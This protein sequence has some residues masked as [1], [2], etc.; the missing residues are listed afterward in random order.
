[1][2]IERL[3]ILMVGCAGGWF[4]HVGY[5]ARERRRR[6]RVVIDYSNVPYLSPGNYSSTGVMS[7]VIIQRAKD[8]SRR[9]E[10]TV[11]QSERVSR[12]AAAKAHRRR[13][14]A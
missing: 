13:S 5:T 1:M 4:A 9:I 6:A 7:D 3:V 10:D 11:D 8:Q 14:P 12:R 2:S